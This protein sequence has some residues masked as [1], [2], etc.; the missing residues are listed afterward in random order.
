MGPVEGE[1]VAVG[2]SR[3]SEET[4]AN[5]GMRDRSCGVLFVPLSFLV[6]LVLGEGDTEEGSEEEEESKRRGEAA[7]Q[8]GGEIRLVEAMPCRSWSR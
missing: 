2:G 1:G 6:F 3:G 8:D 5:S 4:G 7:R